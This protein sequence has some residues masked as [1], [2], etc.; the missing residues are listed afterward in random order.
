MDVAIRGDRAC[1]LTLQL[2]TQSWLFAVARGFGTIDGIAAAP[3]A[4]SRIRSECERRL[5]SERFRRSVSRPEAAATAMLAI[6]SRINAEIFTR[7]AAHDDYVTAGCSFSAAVVVRG[8]AYVIHT[9]GTAVYLAHGA[10]LKWL[11]AQD[12]FDDGPLPI[13]ARALGTTGSLDVALTSV[14]VEPGDLIILLAHRVPGELD[15]RALIAHVEAAAPNE[16]VLVVR[17]DDGDRALCGSPSERSNTHASVHRASSVLVRAALCAAGVAFLLA[18][19][20]GW[21][22]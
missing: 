20:S 1:S 3:S 15:R 16:Q 8:R 13:L 14:G 4:L 9:G 5:K 19:L 7:S 21:A 6:L 12:S 2:G 18:S 17:F 22:Q 11:T 10:E